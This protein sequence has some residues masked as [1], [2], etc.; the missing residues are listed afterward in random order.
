[1]MQ[2]TFQKLVNKETISEMHAEMNIHA[3]IILA[4]GLIAA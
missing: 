4:G 3:T 1:M 2:L